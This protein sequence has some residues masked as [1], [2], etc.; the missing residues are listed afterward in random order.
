MNGSYIGEAFPVIGTSVFWM[1]RVLRTVAY[2]IAYTWIYNHTG[3][4]TL[5]AILV[6]F[7]VNV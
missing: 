5:S 7:A 6:T 4:S 2:S 1:G 3:R